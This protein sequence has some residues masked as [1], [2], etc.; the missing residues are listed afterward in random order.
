[1]SDGGQIV[2]PAFLRA[3]LNEMLPRET[4]EQRARRHAHYEQMRLDQAARWAALTPVQRMRVR[5]RLRVV[6]PMRA[7]RRELGMRI[8]GL[9]EDDLG[10]DW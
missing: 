9:T 5:F 8:A 7:K 1:V 10:G 3:M 6:G 2:P 4:P